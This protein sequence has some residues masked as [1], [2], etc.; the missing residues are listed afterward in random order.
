MSNSKLSSDL[1][2]FYKGI[3]FRRTNVPASLIGKKYL[4]ELPSGKVNKYFVIQKSFESFLK[5]DLN[6]LSY[7]LE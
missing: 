6:I 3:P 4:E 2:L 5:I 7:I 1:S